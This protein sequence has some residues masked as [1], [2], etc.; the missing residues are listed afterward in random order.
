MAVVH[1]Q[2]AHQPGVPLGAIQRLHKTIEV[3]RCSICR[4]FVVRD[5]GD[6]GLWRTP[7]DYVTAQGGQ[8]T[9]ASLF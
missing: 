4:R 6:L 1:R 3:N 8:A 7:T 2:H 5:E 9:G